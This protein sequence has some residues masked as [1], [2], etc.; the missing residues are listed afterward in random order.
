MVLVP[1]NCFH[2][3][4]IPE[5]AAVWKTRSWSVHA[6]KTRS[7]LRMSPITVETFID[8]NG[9]CGF[10]IIAV[11]SYPCSSNCWTR[12]NP[13]NPLAPVTNA[14]TRTTLWLNLQKTRPVIKGHFSE[15]HR[16]SL[17][18]K[19]LNNKSLNIKPN[20]NDPSSDLNV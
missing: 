15:R 14:F 6:S 19:G 17:N 4:Q 16:F 12:Q 20:L 18:T 7:K 8:A 5:M 13:K 3:P 2:G 9:A 1:W 10:R 11:T